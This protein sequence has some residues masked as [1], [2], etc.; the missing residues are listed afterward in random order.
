MLTD[1]VAAEAFKLQRNFRILFWGFLF[2]PLLALAAGLFSE[3]VLEG[4]LPPEARAASAD[5]AQQGLN[6]FRDAASPLTILFA[7]IG[8]AVL[9][10]GEYR[11][12]TWRLMAPRNTRVNHLAGK[13]VVFAVASL[14]TVLLTG[15]AGLLA[16]LVGGL[17]TGGGVEWN[18]GEGYF[19]R[20]LGYA[21]LAWLMLLQAG[22]VAALAGVATRSIMAALMVPIGLGIA[23]AV[24]HAQTAMARM[25][26]PSEVE[27]W[28]LLALPSMSGDLIRAWLG[29]QMMLPGQAVTPAI[30]LTALACLLAWLAAGFGGA[31]ALFRWQ[32]LSKE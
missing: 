27:A 5:L 32:D 30:A 18:A 2:I 26:E 12:E 15:L 11:W 17:A 1:A 9:F 31:V 10:A 20:L 23:Q 25:V 29:G 4:Q 7:L 8:A 14:A 13:V 6:A 21:G 16:G 3:F 22:A 28:R 19:G 24:L